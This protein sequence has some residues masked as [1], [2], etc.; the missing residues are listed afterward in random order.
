MSWRV[1]FIEDSEHISLYLDN[2]KIIKDQNDILIPLCDINTLIIDNYKL[3][4]TVQLMNALTKYNINV[5]FC[6]ID[7]LPESSLIP[8]SGHHLA[9]Q[10]LSNQ[11]MWSDQIKRRIHAFII[12][13]KIRMQKNLLY[14]FQC[15]YNAI[16]LINNMENDV[17]DGDQTNRE[18]L[19][20]KIY[21]KALFGQNF[22]RF[23][24]DVINAG[25]NYGYSII[26]SMVSRCLVSKG[27]NTAIGFFHKGQS[28]AFNL[29][30]DMMEPLR[31]IVDWWVKKYLYNEVIFKK[32]HRIELIKLTTKDIYYDQHRQT[33]LNGILLFVEAIIRNIEQNE[34][35]NIDKL[36][37]NYNEL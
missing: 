28:N 9:A 35:L 10:K 19:V 36:Y 22:K 21:F 14:H 4:L 3:N 7:H 12:K 5:V 13:L 20:A 26:R 34:P 17:Q 6:G 18:G 1:I 15:D 11:L 32:E 24:D 27:L 8:L 37:I 29:S 33:M 23:D 30:D 31:P 25:L 2:I 16:K